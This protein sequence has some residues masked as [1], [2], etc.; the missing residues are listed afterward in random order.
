M[1]GMG[2]CGLGRRWRVGGRGLERRSGGLEADD[3]VVELMEALVFMVEK[4]LL[5]LCKDGDESVGRWVEEDLK[6]EEDW[7][8]SGA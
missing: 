3:G 8:L 2:G 1:S 4:G 7:M 6:K 5:R